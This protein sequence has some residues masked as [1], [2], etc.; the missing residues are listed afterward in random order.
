MSETVTN[1]AAEKPDDALTVALK[2][3]GDAC[4]ALGKYETEG[5]GGTVGAFLLIQHAQKKLDAVY[6]T[7][8]REHAEVVAAKDTAL[9]DARNFQACWNAACHDISKLE[10][11]RDLLRA[12][13]EELE[14]D[15]GRLRS[16]L[17]YPRFGNTA[18]LLIR[19]CE[20]LEARLPK[21][22]GN[23]GCLIVPHLQR[24]ADE[25]KVV[26]ALTAPARDTSLPP[27]PATSGGESPQ[28][29][30]GGGA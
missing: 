23:H 18:N 3:Y 1:P 4:H 10:S 15:K 29:E 8:R 22:G 17:M 14:K 24:A 25:M 28:P 19:A 2:E 13:V 21:D 20:T 26:M 16:V 9:A 30:R 12:R 27:D 5:A 6:S 7:A 11:N